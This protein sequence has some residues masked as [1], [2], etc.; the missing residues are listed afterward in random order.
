M[1]SFRTIL[2]NLRRQIL[3]GVDGDSFF[4]RKTRKAKRGLDCRWLGSEEE[5]DS[6]SEGNALGGNVIW[7]GLYIPP[8]DAGTDKASNSAFFSCTTVTT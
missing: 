4:L 6:R 1:G 5:A 3:C 7:L 2:D 8:Q